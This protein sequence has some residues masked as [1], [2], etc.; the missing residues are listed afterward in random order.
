MMPEPLSGQDAAGFFLLA[1]KV[2]ETQKVVKWARCC[3][4]FG[5]Y[6][7]YNKMASNETNDIDVFTNNYIDRSF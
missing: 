5:G 2:S 4:L 3:E 6:F 7:W 1:K